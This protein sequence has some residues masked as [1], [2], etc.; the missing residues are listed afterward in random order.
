MLCCVRLAIRCGKKLSQHLFL[1]TNGRNRSFSL[2]RHKTPAGDV[3]E[4]PVPVIVD[5]DPFID[6]FFLAFRHAH[7]LSGL[8]NHFGD[9]HGVIDGH[10]RAVRGELDVLYF[11]I[12]V[13]GFELS[14]DI[15]IPRRPRPEV[16]IHEI[17]VP[18]PI[19]ARAVAPEFRHPF[20]QA[21]FVGT[22]AGRGRPGFAGHDAKQVGLPLFASFVAKADRDRVKP[23]LPIGGQARGLH[24]PRAPV[25][26]RQILFQ[27]SLAAVQGIVEIHLVAKRAPILPGDENAPFTVGGDFRKGGGTVVRGSRIQARRFLEVYA[28][29]R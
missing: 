12:V 17:V 26:E 20:P 21:L 29:L 8:Q 2:P 24:V 16:R 1:A 25:A 18:P 15:Q 11:K 27:P 23:T 3:L 22:F 9:F 5:P 13:N 6:G 14:S 4:H 28:V 7:F 10:L 19:G